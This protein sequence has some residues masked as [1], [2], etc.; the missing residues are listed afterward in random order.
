M[1]KKVARCINSYKPDTAVELDGH[2]NQWHREDVYR[3]HQSGAFQFLSVCGLCREGYNDPGIQ[4]VAI[5]RPT[6]S[7][8][9]AEQMKGRGCRP[10][11]GCVNSTMTRDERLAAIAASV[12]PSC[13]IIDLVGVTGMADCASTAHI[14]GSGLPDEVIERANRN[15]LAKDG[16]VDVGEELRKARKQID[17]EE[18]ERRKKEREAKEAAE[19]AE[20]ERRGRLKSKVHYT[21][22]PVQQGTGMR[23][24]NASGGRRGPVMIFGKHK[25]KPLSEIPQGYLA[26]VAA[27]CKTQWLRRAARYELERR[28]KQPIGGGR[29]SVDEVNAVLSSGW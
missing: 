27:E 28:T 2:H 18:R 16:P 20:A 12:K 14:L 5:F 19:R 17:D 10:L 9:L 22:V 6:K 29:M 23:N 4:A 1:A 24:H 11:R 21:A 13:M 8:P 7:R 25:G 26:W 15:A 3:R